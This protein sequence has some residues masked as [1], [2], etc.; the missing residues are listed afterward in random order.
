MAIISKSAILKVIKNFDSS[1]SGSLA[2]FIILH[3]HLGRKRR[4][5]KF[6][7]I[8]R[9]FFAEI[10]PNKPLEVPHCSSYEAISVMVPCVEKDWPLLPLCLYGIEKNILNHVKKIFVVTNNPELTTNFKSE[11]LEIVQEKNLIGSD[12]NNLINKYVPADRRG[13]VI[14]QILTFKF[15]YDN[16]DKNLLVI[17]ADTVLSRP[18]LFIR[19]GKQV[20]T[21]VVEYNDYDASTTSIT[22]GSKGVPFGISFTSHHVLLQTDLVR[23]MFDEIG[24]FGKGIEKWLKSA[25]SVP[26]R[27]ISDMHSYGTWLLNSYPERVVFARWGNI[28][29][30][31]TFLKQFSKK[32]NLEI[33]KQLQS[34]FKNYN[35]ISLHHYLKD[36]FIGKE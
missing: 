26:W 3:T 31:K 21:P 32:S 33:F 5:W 24:G 8:L 2:K 25:D 19:D 28:R 9:V 30:S 4:T 34:D 11:I 27:P 13:W 36:G 10:L 12:L 20:L 22:W 29:V 35:S 1:I 17:D 16:L 7:Y 15:A 14:K 18:R 6:P 23:E